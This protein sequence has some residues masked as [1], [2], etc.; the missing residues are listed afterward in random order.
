MTLVT[1]HQTI[2]HQNTYSYGQPDSQSFQTVSKSQPSLPCHC[3]AP[4]PPKGGSPSHCS[5]SLSSSSQESPR[6]H[7][8]SQGSLNGSS[9]RHTSD[10]S[11][12]MSP[13][14][15]KRKT[16]PLPS[17][18]KEKRTSRHLSLD[19]TPTS[20]TIDKFICSYCTRQRF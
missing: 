6:P 16:S 7:L 14:I 9:P 19:G 1:F 5:M 20:I 11:L 15:P 17:P 8:K 10:Q 2:S 4:I 18:G 3:Q 12:K 13:S